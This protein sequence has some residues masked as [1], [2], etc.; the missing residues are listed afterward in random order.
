MGCMQLSSLVFCLKD[1]AGC[2][3]RGV[4]IL[5]NCSGSCLVKSVIMLSPHLST[6]GNNGFLS[7]T[8]SG[9]L[10]IPLPRHCFQSNHPWFQVLRWSNE[11]K[12]EFGPR[13][14][15]RNQEKSDLKRMPS[16]E[17]VK[18]LKKDNHIRNI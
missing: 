8:M 6:N 11:E 18:H 10:P 17:E 14:M 2:K 15:N 9:R 12:S 1:C 13:W 4:E 16:K 3:C 7:G 5:I